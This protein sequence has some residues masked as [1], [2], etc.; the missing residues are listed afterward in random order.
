MKESKGIQL[1]ALL[2]AMLLIGM[3]FVPAVGA[4]TAQDVG[5]TTSTDCPCSQGIDIADDPGAKVKTTELSGVKRNE[6]MA[7]ALSDKGILKL[8]EELIKSGYKPSI[9]KNQCDEIHHGE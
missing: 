4:Q 5:V 6:V 1:S 2:M 3:V 8:R 9:E 7:Q